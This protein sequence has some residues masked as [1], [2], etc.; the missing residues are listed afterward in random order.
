MKNSLVNVQKRR[1]NII[2]S[3]GTNELI[4]VHELSKMNKVSE[5][6]VRRDLKVLSDM[7]L[8]EWRNG[9]VSK[10]P[11]EKENG[12]QSDLNIR[13]LQQNI[14]TT[15]PD[16][17]EDF[18]TVFA[19]SSSLCWQA[20][21][22]L[23]HKRLTVVTN[24]IRAVE[25]AHHPHTSIILTGGEVNYPKQSLIGSV[26]TQFID[27][28]KADYCLLGCDGISLTGGITSK[29][30]HESKVNAAMVDNTKGMVICLVDYRKVGVVSN[31]RV[32]DI[33]SIDILIT[34]KFSNR[35]LLNSF[36]ERNIKVVQVTD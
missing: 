13:N 18:S 29:D 8:V 1:E 30:I 5:I 24:N 17:V 27:S 35:S 33:D 9:I 12:V 21:N 11:L 22:T 4:S 10:P 28:I 26:A 25:C 20:I 34:D 14:I 23:V 31:Y 19:N 32:A 15:V 7:G 6:T 36:S 2:K 3:F 16:F